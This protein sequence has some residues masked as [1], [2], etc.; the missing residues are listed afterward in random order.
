MNITKK[1]SGDFFDEHFDKCKRHF[2]IIENKNKVINQLA[3]TTQE[4][5]FLNDIF[6]GVVK[7]IHTQQR[8]DYDA[9]WWALPPE[10]RDKIRQINFEKSCKIMQSMMKFEHL[11][12]KKAIQQE[13][14]KTKK[15]FFEILLNILL[16]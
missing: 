1:T 2:E 13:Q 8:K 5:D 3:T 10:E 12:N 6:D 4:K 15:G 14:K 7:R 11:Q 9:R 16:K